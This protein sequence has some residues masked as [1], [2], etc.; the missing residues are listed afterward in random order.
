M[1]ERKCHLDNYCL[2]NNIIYQATIKTNNITKFYAG[3]TT[4]TFK[5]R[6]SNHKASF[7]NKLKRHNT[8][9]SNYTW[10]LKDAN[11][12]CNSKW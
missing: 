7:N 8:E 11:K 5:N 9:L 6:Y 10:E 4:T 1:Q 2:A 12:D 3:S